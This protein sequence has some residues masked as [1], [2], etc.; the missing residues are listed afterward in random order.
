MSNNLLIVLLQVQNATMKLRVLH[1]PWDQLCVII[2]ADRYVIIR[3]YSP[4]STAV[5][6][7]LRRWEIRAR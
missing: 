1:L 6:L 4:H 7:F 3:K 2:S 5:K